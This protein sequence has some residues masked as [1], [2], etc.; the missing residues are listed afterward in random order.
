L[1]ERAL[2]RRRR[3]NESQQEV[4]ISVTT[5][6][7]AMFEDSFLH[8]HHEHRAYFDERFNQQEQQQLQQ[9]FERL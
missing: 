8:L 3:S 4:L 7:E 1:E 5:L 6:G 2:V 9:L